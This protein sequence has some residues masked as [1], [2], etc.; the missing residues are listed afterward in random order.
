MLPKRICILCEGEVQNEQMIAEDFLTFEV[1]ELTFDWTSTWLHCL[2]K[3][4]E[5]E[6]F[7]PDLCLLLHLVESKHIYQIPDTPQQ[8]VTVNYTQQF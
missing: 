3:Y 8:Q 1:L 7:P 6:S 5:V 4:A 2:R